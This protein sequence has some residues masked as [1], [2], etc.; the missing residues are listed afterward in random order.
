[1]RTTITVAFTLLLAALG[2]GPKPPSQQPPA[3]HPTAPITDRQ[4][5][6]ATLGERAAPL[7]AGG[8][9]ATLGLD[10]VT[11]RAVGF[12]GCN[13]FSASYRLSGDSLSFGPVASTRMACTDG[14]ELER[15]FLAA[16]P[17]VVTYQVTDSALTLS[18]P[19]GTLAR[20]RTP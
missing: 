10:S 15:S 18:G 14:D 7:G 20:F 19:G 4:W 8:R 5:T 12:A 16:L 1:M 11:S 6:L 3:S 9:P 17:A 13:R 2:C